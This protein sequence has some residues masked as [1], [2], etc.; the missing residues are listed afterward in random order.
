MNGIEL[1]PTQLLKRKAVVYVAH[2]GVIWL[3]IE[4]TR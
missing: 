4:R 3:G 1:I 2:S